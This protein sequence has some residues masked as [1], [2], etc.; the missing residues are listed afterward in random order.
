MNHF[1]TI[2]WILQSI[3]H[4]IFIFQN[5][6]KLSCVMGLNL[7]QEEH[8]KVKDVNMRMNYSVQSVDELQHRIF[9]EF[10]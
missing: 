4:L 6:F 10:E 3:A 8:S 7:Q 1:Q 2:Y 9:S 5:L